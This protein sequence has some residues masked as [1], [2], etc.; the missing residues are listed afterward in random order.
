M[1]FFECIIFAINLRFWYF[2]ILFS[3]SLMQSVIQQPNFIVLH[4]EQDLF[5]DLLI[6]SSCFLLTEFKCIHFSLDYV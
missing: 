5:L 2:W 3:I 4:F 6:V 1:N